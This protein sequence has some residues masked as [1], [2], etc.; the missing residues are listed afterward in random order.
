MRRSRDAAVDEAAVDEAAVDEAA[1]DEAAD[2][3]SC[4][5][6]AAVVS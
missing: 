5:L 3:R 1:V 4:L 6:T 2:R